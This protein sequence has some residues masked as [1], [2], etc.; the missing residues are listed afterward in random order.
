MDDSNQLETQIDLHDLPDLPDGNI[1]QQNLLQQQIQENIPRTKYPIILL[2]VD[3]IVIVFILGFL[4]SLTDLG[5]GI[6]FFVSFMTLSFAF[7]PILYLKF[8]KYDWKFILRFSI[9]NLSKSILLFSMLITLNFVDSFVFFIFSIQEQKDSEENILNDSN[10][11][12]F[13]VWISIS[14]LPGICEEIFFRGFMQKVMEYNFQ[15]IKKAILITSL[16]FS[17][18]HFDFSFFG[19]LYKFLLGYI[20]GNFASRTDSIFPSIISHILNNTMVLIFFLHADTISISPTVSMVLFLLSLAVFI[21]LF[22]FFIKKNDYIGIHFPNRN[23]IQR[24]RSE[25]EMN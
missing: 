20:F 9:S 10:E 7:V 24:N 3:Y 4:V 16:I 1:E 2:I 11:P 14:L 25:F 23:L 12:V 8:A 13:L 18:S 15:N 17:F 21:L 19:F 22:Y 5:Q 6:F